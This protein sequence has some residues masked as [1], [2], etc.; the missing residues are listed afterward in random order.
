MHSGCASDLFGKLLHK[1]NRIGNLRCG[2]ILFQSAPKS[3][4]I[5]ISKS[6]RLGIGRYEVDYIERMWLFTKRGP[7]KTGW[8]RREDDRFRQ[9][10]AGRFLFGT[11]S[12]R[13]Q[14]RHTTGGE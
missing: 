11:A 12:D 10:G 5:E 3:R 9:I 8:S 13:L 2:Q 6:E 1:V 14:S 4:K 7:E